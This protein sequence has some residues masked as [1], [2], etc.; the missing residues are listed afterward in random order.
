M[1]QKIPIKTDSF[2]TLFHEKDQFKFLSLLKSTR[3]M[4]DSSLLTPK[5]AALLIYSYCKKIP[6]PPDSPI[7]SKLLTI[8]N[9]H[10]SLMNPQDFVNVL[11]AFS[12]ILPKNT[13]L[14]EELENTLSPIENSLK[15]R[16]RVTVIHSFG[17]AIQGSQTFWVQ[18]ELFLERNLNFL[19]EKELSIVVWSIAKSDSRLNNRELWLK[20]EARILDIKP[21]NIEDLASLCY[22]F[23]R[24]QVGSS[25]L[26]R[27]FE[28][29]MAVNLK[30]MKPRYFANFLWAFAKSGS[31]K[32]ENTLILDH[33]GGWVLGEVKAGGY[34]DLM[35]V[36]WACNKMN[37]PEREGFWGMVFKGLEK[38]E[39]E[40][41]NMNS[42]DLMNLA[43]ILIQRSGVCEFE[44]LWKVLGKRFKEY[45]QECLTL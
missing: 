35:N 37:I 21:K 29:M 32:I 12:K 7:Q 8:Y 19:P 26:W 11:W 45:L 38:R 16:E 20:I 13:L 14:F 42:Q 22:S 23:G 4:E 40:I 25:D 9:T 18:Q 15:L 41:F 43:W 10:K 2:W 3:F 36:L 44:G 27:Y 24:K 1:F 31:Y 6:Q 17:K 33:L 28:T 34:R 39:K 5:T 30:S